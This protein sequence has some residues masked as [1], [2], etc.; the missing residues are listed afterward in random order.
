MGEMMKEIENLCQKYKDLESDKLLIEEELKEEQ[1]KNEKLNEKIIELKSDQL[2]SV[3][4]R[5]EIER[6]FC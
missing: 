2:N 4:L 1:L 6:Y 5:N 3:N